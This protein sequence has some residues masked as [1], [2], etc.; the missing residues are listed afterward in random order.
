MKHLKLYENMEEFEIGDHV[1]TKY[2]VNN[3]KGI[4]KH[5]VII[6][7]KR[8][9]KTGPISPEM[10]YKVEDKNCHVDWINNIDIK[11][12]M[13]KKEI[14]AFEFDYQITKYNL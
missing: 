12:K 8:I 4:V 7:K 1:M 13:N 2:Y 14:E 6:D 3:G 9:P 11:R 5:F 10:N